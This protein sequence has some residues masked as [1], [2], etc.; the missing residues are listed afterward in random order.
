[1]YFYVSDRHAY[2][3]TMRYTVVKESY[4]N[5]ERLWGDLVVLRRVFIRFVCVGLL[6]GCEYGS[7]LVLH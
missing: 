2:T 6:E 3:D 7:G 4:M 5:V 1:M